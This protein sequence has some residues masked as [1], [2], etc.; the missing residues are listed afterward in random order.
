[1]F[2]MEEFGI[3]VFNENVLNGMSDMLI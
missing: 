1:V 3:L 2:K